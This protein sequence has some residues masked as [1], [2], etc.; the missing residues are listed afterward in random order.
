MLFAAYH[1]AFANNRIIASLSD[2]K[3]TPFQLTAI[4]PFQQ[5]TGK[6]YTS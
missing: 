1:K 3:P 4:T 5:E 2:R 6:A